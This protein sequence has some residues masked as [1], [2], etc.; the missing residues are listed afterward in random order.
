[1]RIE[2]WENRLAQLCAAAQM[3]PFKRGTHDCCTFAR[4]VEIA[5]IG[6]SLFA[7]SGGWRTAG[8]AV[9]TLRRMGFRSIRAMLDARLEPC[10]PAMARRG[11]IIMT[12]GPWVDDMGAI[13]V[14]IGIHAVLPGPDGLI[15]VPALSGAGAWRID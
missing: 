12:D 11:D 1:M 4:D 15:R 2:G 9:R 6:Q 14:V 5:L 7:D 3:R 8:G 10:I 13:A